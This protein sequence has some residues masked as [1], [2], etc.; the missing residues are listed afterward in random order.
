MVDI[1]WSEFGGDRSWCY[2]NCG[3]IFRSHAK[4][5]I[6]EGGD[7]IHAFERQC[8]GCDSVDDV[9]R[10][11]MDMEKTSLSSDDIEVLDAGSPD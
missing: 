8:P 1:D 11:S 3:S 10:V 5:V 9:Y 4:L 6:D 2:C 7:L